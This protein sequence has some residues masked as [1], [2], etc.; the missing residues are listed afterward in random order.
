MNAVR[1]A[2]HHESQNAPAAPARILAVF[3]AFVTRQMGGIT[4]LGE[5][6]SLLSDET[7]PSEG[8][9]GPQK[10]I[11]ELVKTGSPMDWR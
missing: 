10:R 5:P 7:L 6:G 2:L 9:L 8:W 1:P 4:T 3:S 11:Q